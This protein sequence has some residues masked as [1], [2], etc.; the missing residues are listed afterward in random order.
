ML[1]I[2]I[3]S[4]GELYDSTL[5]F[6]DDSG[7][8]VKR[9][10]PRRYTG[11]IKG[12]DNTSVLF[13]RAAD[14]PYK[15][16]EGSADI[17]ITGLD[18]FLELGSDSGDSNVVI[19]ALG[20]GSCELVIAVP[21]S[22]IDVDSM[23]DLADLAFDFRENGQDLRI[24]TKYPRLVQNHLLTYGINYYSIVQSSGT[25][26]AA[27]AMGF[28]DIIADI[29]SSGN[30]IRENRLKT[31]DGGSIL[32]SQACIIVNE[33]TLREDADAIK[34]ARIL[35]ELV[36]AY[37]RARN[38]FRITANVSGDSPEEISK[39]LATEPNVTGLKGPT[40][41]RVYDGESGNWYAVT[42]VVPRDI[43]IKTVDHIRKIGGGSLTVSQENYVFEQEST[44]Y[45]VLLNS[46]SK[47]SML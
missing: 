29:S 30:T 47:S 25:L 9:S 42:M 46:V 38:F 31:I 40:I 33:R 41:S 37:V 16:E 18:R 27:P 14:I 8:T 13:Q 23:Y 12:V 26:E 10:S 32:T 15:V 20:F 1:R 7:L 35:L 11:S 36:E 3:P 17:G 45:T 6:L 5:K 21:D 28:A 4:D 22:W 19:E 39:K 2:A 24:A 44:S 43:L 34:S